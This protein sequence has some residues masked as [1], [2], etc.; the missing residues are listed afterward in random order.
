M[1]KGIKIKKGV[2]IAAALF[3]VI[4]LLSA[5]QVGDARELENNYP[6]IPLPGQGNFSLNDIYGAIRGE[7][8][9]PAYNTFKDRDALTSLILY[10]Y[11]FA[12]AIVGLIAFGVIIM[13]GVRFMSSGANPSLRATAMKQLQ[14][15]L[16][17]I[18]I[19]LGSVVLL[20]I[21]NPELALL[22]PPDPTKSSFRPLGLPDP[23][24]IREAQERSFARKCI[25]DGA[26]GGRLEEQTVGTLRDVAEIICADKTV[27][28]TDALIN[29]TLTSIVNKTECNQQDVIVI[30]SIIEADDTLCGSGKAPSKEIVI[31]DPKTGASKIVI[32]NEQ[33]VDREVCH[34]RGAQLGGG[35]FMFSGRGTVGTKEINACVG[36]N[37]EDKEEIFRLVKANASIFVSFCANNQGSKEACSLINAE[38]PIADFTDQH[39]DALTEYC[40]SILSCAAF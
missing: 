29:Q 3:A 7:T 13:T 20:N 19:L 38:V 21:I 23:G 39:Q 15:V 30:R 8:D 6:K 17:G 18:A 2:L 28:P 34:D 32:L 16:L 24:A 40:L 1:N 14:S 4:L 11:T 26:G 35:G 27:G 25:G 10:F 36:Q 31:V 9:S 37:E 12:V 5:P 22:T 33:T